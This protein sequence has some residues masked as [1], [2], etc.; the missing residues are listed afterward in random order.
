MLL[1]ACIKIKNSLFVA[2]LIIPFLTFFSSLPPSLSLSLSLFDIPFLIVSL[3]SLSLC[4][5]LY[6]SLVSSFSFSITTAFHQ[7]FFIYFQCYLYLSLSLSRMSECLLFFALFL[8]VNIYLSFLCVFFSF[9]I[10]IPFHQTFICYFLALTEISS[11]LSLQS[12]S[13]CERLYPLY[14]SMGAWVAEWSLHSTFEHR[15]AMPWAVRSIL[16]D[17]Y[18]FL[19]QA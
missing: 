15:Y 9:S 16:G 17:N 1:A 7:T 10:T 11:F 3:C 18:S 13:L 8:Y 2:R 14:G 4:E 6:T 5:C 19:A 12:I